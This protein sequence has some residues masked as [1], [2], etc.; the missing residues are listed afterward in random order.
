MSVYGLADGLG[1]CQSALSLL[2]ARLCEY[3]LVSFRRDAQTLH[4]RVA[5]P[6]A[7]RILKTLRQIFCP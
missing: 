6:D 7:I 2:L 3:G 1:L 5:N 4:Y